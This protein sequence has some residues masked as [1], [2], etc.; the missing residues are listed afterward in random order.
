MRPTAE[1]LHLLEACL[2][3][4]PEFVRKK[5]RCVEPTLSSV[6]AGAAQMGLSWAEW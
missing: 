4:V 5:S 1:E 2:R 6:A 3:E